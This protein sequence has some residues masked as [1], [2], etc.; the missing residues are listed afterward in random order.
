MKAPEIVR[1]GHVILQ[2]AD[3]AA[4]RA[5]YV[6]LLGLDVVVSPRAITVRL[7]PRG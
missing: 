2:V 6:G 1:L 3:L 7:T 4:S 5:F